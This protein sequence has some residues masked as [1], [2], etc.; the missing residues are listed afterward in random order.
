MTRRVRTAVLISGYGS[1]L[2]ALLDAAKAADYPAEIALVISNE[3]NAY[4][5]LRAEQAKIPH[6]TISHRGHPTREDFDR[7]LD[8][9]LKEHGI[10]LVCLAGFMRILSHEFVQ[11]WEGRLINIHPSLLPKFPGLDTHVR[12]L[13]AKEKL[14]GATVHFVTAELDAGPAIAQASLKVER[15]D[16]PESLKTRVHALEHVLYPE[17]LAK[18]ASAL[19]ENGGLI[20]IA[21]GSEAIQFFRQ[22]AGLPRRAIE[23]LAMTRRGMG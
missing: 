20:V 1:N 2:Q 19:G 14:H 16:T 8:A 5:L 18:V 4:G 13:A 3:A 17:A 6:L 23:L 22:Q 11:H 9:A 7:A 10:E 21:S 12:A 15:S